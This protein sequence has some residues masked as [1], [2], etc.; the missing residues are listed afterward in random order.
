MYQYFKNNSSKSN[1][2]N[3][4]KNCIITVV[5]SLKITASVPPSTTN[6]SITHTIQAAMTPNHDSVYQQK[7]TLII[8]LSIS[9][10]IRLIVFHLLIVIGRMYQI[11][12]G[13]FNQ[14]FVWTSNW[15]VQC[16]YITN[17]SFNYLIMERWT[18]LSDC[19]QKKKNDKMLK[20]SKVTSKGLESFICHH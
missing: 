16:T 17:T 5:F 15:T 12:C 1:N 13:Q 20:S 10:I 7:T 11:L 9:I 19:I 2:N 4:I 6:S 3:S 8:P 18:W 14:T